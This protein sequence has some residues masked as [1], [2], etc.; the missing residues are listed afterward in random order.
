M[1]ELYK[2]RE[3][4]EKKVSG[5]NGWRVYKGIRYRVEYR[6]SGSIKAIKV[7]CPKCGREGNVVA[8]L[9]GRRKRMNVYHYG[10]RTHRCSFGICDPLF[11]ILKELYYKIRCNIME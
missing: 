6:K 4:E 11:D 7:L 5:E 2:L 3:R 10:L 8:E 9:S 1:L